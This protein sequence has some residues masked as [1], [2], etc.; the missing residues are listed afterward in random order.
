MRSLLNTHPFE[1][2]DML[3]IVVTV[4]FVIVV[5]QAI[6][7]WALSRQVGILFERVSPMGALVTDAGP[8][9][10]A[11]APRF[12]LRSLTDAAPV[13][14]GERAART[15]L[16]FFLSPHC[17]VCKKL[18]PILRSLNAAEGSTLN[19]IL[20]SDGDEAEHRRF[21]ETHRLQRLAYVLSAPMGV[22]YRVSR[23]PFAAVIGEDG[24]VRAKGLVNNREQLE[25]LLNAKDLG[26][27]SV[28]SYIELNHLTERAA[29]QPRS[30]V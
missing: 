4:L 1:E 15:T 5:A 26:V 14:I 19:L 20:A 30:V 9:I 6:A 13:T 29:V 2:L 17:P 25:S 23:L 22:A 24:T 12:Q 3:P 27:A 8:A 7:I 18:L 21:I 11:P 28:Q 10:G 16:L